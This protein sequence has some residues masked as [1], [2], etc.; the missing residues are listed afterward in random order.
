M[1]KLAATAQGPGLASRLEALADTVAREVSDRRDIESDRAKPRTSARIVTIVMISI[2]TYFL[3]TGGAR[4]D[5]Y[6]QPLGQLVLTILLSLFVLLLLLIRRMTHRPPPATLHAP[7]QPPHLGETA[8]PPPCSPLSWRRPSSAPALSLADHRRA[9][10]H[11]ARPCVTSPPACTPTTASPTRPATNPGRDI[12]LS[13]Q[14]ASEPKPRSPR[15]PS[16]PPSKTWP[17]S[18]A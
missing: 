16:K 4:T 13:A 7:L 6:R 2:T 8:C 5:A 18:T 3:I 9:A 12:P 14:W 17:S 10:A 15:A 11:G 1:L